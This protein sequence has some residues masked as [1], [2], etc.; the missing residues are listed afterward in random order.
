MRL[1]RAVLSSLAWL[2]MP[3]YVA[4]ALVMLVY[5]LT[6]ERWRRV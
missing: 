4:I 2:A 5:L 1:L 6:W 3:V